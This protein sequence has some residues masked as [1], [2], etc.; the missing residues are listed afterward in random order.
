MRAKAA[1]D[2]LAH[3][4]HSECLLGQVVRER[5]ALMRHETPDVL[6][7]NAQPPEQI[8]FLALPAPAPLAPG[9]ALGLGFSMKGFAALE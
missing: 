7:I 1:Q 8:E 6:A 3:F 9:I 2:L 5:H 4:G